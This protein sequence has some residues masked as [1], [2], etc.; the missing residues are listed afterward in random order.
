MARRHWV[1]FLEEGSDFDLGEL[2]RI[3][4]ISKQNGAGPKAPFPVGPLKEKKTFGDPISKGVPKLVLKAQLGADKAPRHKGTSGWGGAGAASKLECQGHK[5]TQ[6]LPRLTGV[7]LSTARTAS[8][9][10]SLT[11]SCCRAEHSR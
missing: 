10:T 5:R 8:A 4:G 7:G 11:P 9:N 1:G 2:S 6:D 3:L